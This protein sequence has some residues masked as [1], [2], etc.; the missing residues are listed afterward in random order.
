MSAPPSASDQSKLTIAVVGLG[1]IG[2]VVAGCLAGTGRYDVVACMR[3][4]IGR[5]TLDAPDGPRDVPLLSLTD[6]AQ[7]KPADWVLLCTKAY[8]TAEAATWLAKLCTPSSR[9]AVLQ[10][11]IDQVR[12]V[13]PLVNGASVMPVVVYYNG[14]RLA[15]DHVRMRQ[16]ADTDIAVADDDGGRAF[17]ELFD[18]TP[19][20]VKCVADIGTLLWRKLL[21]NVIANPITTLTQQRQAVLRRPDIVELGYAILGEAIPVARADG[22]KLAEDE[23]QRAMATLFT[24]SGELGTSM[25]FDRLAGRKMEVEALT[26]AV[27]AAGERHGIATPINAALLAL[28]RA[29]NDAVEKS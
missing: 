5:L 12:S 11:G 24:F 16:G 19:M 27:V 14:E 13:A 6:P 25:Y 29:I 1:S 28:L 22:A 17:A 2:G 7:A 20:R 10:N 4:P 3:R 26:G 23:A 9:V 15:P 21:I 18:G 8:Q